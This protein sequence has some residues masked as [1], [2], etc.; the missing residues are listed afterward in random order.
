[1][2]N[3]RNSM[4]VHGAVPCIL[5]NCKQIYVLQLVCRAV[6]NKKVQ[7]ADLRGVNHCL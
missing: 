1:M 3:S 4:A 2:R 6:A 7:D 5:I